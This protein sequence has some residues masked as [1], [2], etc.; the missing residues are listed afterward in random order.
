M[1]LLLNSNKRLKIAIFYKFFQWI[2][3]EGQYYPANKSKR[4]QENYGAVSL[5]E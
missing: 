2:K 4:L 5:Y 3:E 1:V